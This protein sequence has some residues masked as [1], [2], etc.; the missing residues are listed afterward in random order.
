[1]IGRSAAIIS[2]FGLRVLSALLLL[3]LSAIF[4]PIHGFV[5]FSQFLAFASLLSLAAVGGIQNGLIRQ[6]AVATQPAELGMTHSAGIAIWFAAM[7]LLGVPVL[8][9]RNQISEILTGS[10]GYGDVVVAM[11]GLSIA[12][13]PGQVWCNLLTGRNRTVSS[14]GAQ[15]AGLLAG[16]GLAAWLIAKGS[17]AQAAI[18][19]AAGPL[20]TAAASFAL[21]RALLAPCG[22]PRPAWSEMRQLLHYSAALAAI[23]AVSAVMLFGVRSVYRDAFGQLMLGHWMAAN[24]ISD[25]ST[26]LIGLFMLQAFVPRYSAIDGEAQRRRFVLT[27]G[28]AGMAAMLLPLAIFSIAGEPLVRLFLS[29]AY[30]PAIGM[31]GTYMAGDAL[32]VWTSLT[33]FSAFAVGLPGRFA[34]IEVSVLLVFGGLTLVLIAYGQ[35]AA[36]P[37]AYLATHAIVA[38]GIIALLAIPALRYRIA[39]VKADTA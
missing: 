22:L 27:C 12:A 39:P 23:T 14:L 17:P 5:L 3:K 1:M 36:A 29:D 9:F 21:A 25:M 7:P 33:I 24:R 4:L 6:A 8:L 34:G 15:A 13:G 38:T 37:M 10:P 11:L 20:L 30:L 2:Y 35:Q 32:R 31:I 28:I 19:F 16:T 26:Q 18:A